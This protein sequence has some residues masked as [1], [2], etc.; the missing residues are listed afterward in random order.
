ME[1]SSYCSIKH[2]DFLF[3]GSKHLFI[4][5]VSVYA[6][7]LTLINI[8]LLVNLIKYKGYLKAERSWYCFIQYQFFQHR[9]NCLFLIA[10][11]YFLF[12]FPG[13]VELF[14]L[15]SNTKNVITELVKKLD[16][17][18]YYLHT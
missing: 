13:Q 5:L 8:L 4:L 18:V 10:D 16:L 3:D 6:C 7:S 9:L 1:I 12:D 14:F 2:L 15:H 11:H 17:R